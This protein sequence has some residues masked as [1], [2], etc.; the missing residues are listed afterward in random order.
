MSPLL[1][2]RLSVVFDCAVNEVDGRGKLIGVNGNDVSSCVNGRDTS[3]NG[4]CGTV[5]GVDSPV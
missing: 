4:P 1:G 2:Y 3:V 5:N